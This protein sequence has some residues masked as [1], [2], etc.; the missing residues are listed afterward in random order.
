[1]VQSQLLLGLM[2]IVDVLEM[3]TL[4]SHNFTSQCILRRQEEII[5]IQFKTNIFLIGGLER[6]GIYFTQVHFY[7]HNYHIHRRLNLSLIKIII[8]NCESSICGYCPCIEKELHMIQAIFFLV[9][10]LKY[11]NCRIYYGLGLRE[12]SENCLPK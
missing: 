8:L 10:S 4:Y 6:K 7:S 2:L 12:S 1:M 3:R 9:C 5:A 11:D